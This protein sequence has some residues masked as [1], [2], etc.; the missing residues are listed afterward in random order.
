LDPVSILSELVA[1]RSDVFEGEEAPL[2]NRLAEMLRD[3]KADEVVVVEA[4]RTD[5]LK[6]AS[7]VFARY[8]ENPKL[9]VNAHLDTVPPNADWV[10]DPFK[11]HL[12]EGKLYALGAS[13]TKGAAAAILSALDE[14]TPKSVAVLFSGDEEY[15]S[16]AMR[17]FLASDHAKGIERAIVCEPTNLG[18]GVR[19][20]GFVAFHVTVSSPGGHS[21]RADHVL[22]PIALLARVAVALDDWGKLHKDKGPAGF[23][24]MCLNLAKLDG[25]VAFNVIPAEARLVVSFRPPPGANTKQICTELEQLVAAI[26]GDTA[27]VTWQR[28]NVPFATRDVSSFTALLPK[29]KSPIDLAFWTEAAL[30]SEAGI[31]AV[32]M[33]TGDIAQAHAP[34]EW[35]TLKELEEAKDLFRDLFRRP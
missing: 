5:G 9:V 11:P 1:F 16:V 33:G 23:E 7:W 10:T 15:S 19:H 28:V 17:S 6:A 32:V 12:H 18:V 21:S 35:V 31:D 24:G 14:V 2:A 25:G 20:R 3:R 34:N 4:P 29:A 27:K 8:G 22:S 30:L 13:D 26:A